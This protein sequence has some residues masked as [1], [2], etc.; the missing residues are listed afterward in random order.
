MTSVHFT[1][2]EVLAEL[3]QR[4]KLF[5]SEA[6][7]ARAIGVSRSYLNR[8]M[9]GEKPPE[10]KVLKWLRYKRVEVYCASVDRTKAT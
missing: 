4:C 5:R 2:K 7:M 1:R 3:R 10:G 6:E 8:I 9:R